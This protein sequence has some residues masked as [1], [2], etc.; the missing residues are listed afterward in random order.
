MLVVYD[1]D[2]WWF[3]VVVRVSGFGDW[4]WVWWCAWVLVS[5]FGFGFRVV[6]GFLGLGLGGFLGILRRC[7]GII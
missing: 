5:G 3:V 1:G 4:F 6:F 7:V 2:V